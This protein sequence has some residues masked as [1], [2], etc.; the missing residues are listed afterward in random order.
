MNADI[1]ENSTVKPQPQSPKKTRTVQILLGVLFILPAITALI[2]VIIIPTVRTIGYSFQDASLLGESEPVGLANYERLLDSPITGQALSFTLLMTLS[3]VVIVLIP[4]LLL[5]LG[6]ST[7]KPG[8]RKIMRVIASLPWMVYSPTALGVIWILLVNPLVGFGNQTLSFANPELARWIILFLDGLSFFGLACGLGLT[9]YLSTI[10]GVNS[11]EDKKG[12]WRNLIILATILLVGTIAVSL[13]SGSTVTFVTRGGPQFTTMTFNTMILNQGNFYFQTGIASAMTTPLLILV[14]I[15]GL[16]TALFVILTNT[17]LFKI[18]KESQVPQL[19]KW[20]KIISIIVMMVVIL[21]IL[22][23]IVP[24]IL[25]IIPI[26]RAPGEGFFTQL[27]EV[28]TGDIF[29]RSMLTTWTLPVGIVFLVQFPITYLAALSIG[30]LRPIGKASK[31][32]LML[33][34]P[35]LFVSVL[36]YLPGMTGMLLELDLFNNLAGYALPYLLNIPILFILTLFFRGQH[37]KADREDESGNFF[38][39]YVLPSIPLTLFCLV[40]SVM[41]IQQDLIWSYATTTNILPA[42]FLRLRA[43][44]GI[45]IGGFG[46]LMWL[47]RIPAFIVTLIIFGGFQ[48]LYFPRLGIK[49]GK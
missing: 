32:L 17:R 22:I 5:A 39:T 44:L 34:A 29:W 45:N 27:G 24:Y 48:V 37:Q 47:L 28:T 38:K 13:Q 16:L 40:L 18:S 36:L 10:K 3:R 19:P 33:F 46:G 49:A 42:Y 35:W 31:W 30:A 15:L 11:G 12:L 6:I 4:P 2:L 20:F 25:Q 1:N 7:L 23:S 26:F 43:T 8:F 9:V 14:G 41:F 21:L